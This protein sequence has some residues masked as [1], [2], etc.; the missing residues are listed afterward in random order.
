M[1]PIHIALITESENDTRLT[2]IISPSELMIT[3]QFNHP[4]QI[5]DNANIHDIIVIDSET[6]RES[7]LSTIKKLVS[8]VSHAKIIVI[9]KNPE[10][11]QVRT[12]IQAGVT[13]VILQDELSNRFTYIARTVYAGQIAISPTILKKL[14]VS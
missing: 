1:K 10:V 2:S 9:C 6:V 3:G 5:E 8:K 11:Q 7:V 14:L 12:L 4:Q 13:G